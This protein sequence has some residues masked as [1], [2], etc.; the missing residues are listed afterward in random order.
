MIYNS[1]HNCTIGIF[2]RIRKYG[3]L[4]LLSTNKLSNRKLKEIY[5]KLMDEYFKEY[6]FGDIYLEWIELKCAELEAYEKA[7]IGGDNT[8]KTDA[9]IFEAK[10]N[11]LLKKNK[12][13]S[14]IECKA[15]IHKT[16]GTLIRENEVTVK[17]FNDILENLKN[18]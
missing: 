7:Y 12:G 15:L 14:F 11:N 10:A 2:E 18:G 6:G 4:T 5:I 13:M 9:K 16:Y 1:I 3:D 17:E 8:K